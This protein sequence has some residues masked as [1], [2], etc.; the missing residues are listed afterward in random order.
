MLTVAIRQVQLLRTDLK[1]VA[2]GLRP[3]RRRVCEQHAPVLM[4]QDNR[5]VDAVQGDSRRGGSE[6]FQANP[7]GCW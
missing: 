2:A 6:F 5:Q 1:A 4:Q 3:Q 7:F